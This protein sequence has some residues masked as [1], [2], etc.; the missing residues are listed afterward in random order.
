MVYGNSKNRFNRS[1]ASFQGPIQ[2]QLIKTS[3]TDLGL[4][5]SGTTNG[6]RS[7]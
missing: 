5:E 3:E 7:S 6:M 2:S 1:V 4:A